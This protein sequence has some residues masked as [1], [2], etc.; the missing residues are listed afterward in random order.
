MPAPLARVA[1]EQAGGDVVVAIAEDGG[2]NGDLI[3]DDAANGVTPALD[4]GLDGFDNDPA[5]T[6]GRLHTNQLSAK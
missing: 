5:T 1:V 4:Y 3:V 2:G 6:L